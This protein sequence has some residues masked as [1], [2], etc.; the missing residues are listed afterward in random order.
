MCDLLP[1]KSTTDMGSHPD[2][3]LESTQPLEPWNPVRR[4]WLLLG[5]GATLRGLYLGSKQASD[6]LL[7]SAGL[8]NISGISYIYYTEKSYI[9]SMLLFAWQT[10]GK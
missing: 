9:E 1:I 6:A 3:Y 10:E 8:L 5:A 4:S 2:C 7:I